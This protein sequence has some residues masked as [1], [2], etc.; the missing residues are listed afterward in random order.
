MYFLNLL[1]STG[2]Q[3]WWITS[4]K[5]TSTENHPQQLPLGFFSLS[6]TES[7]PFLELLPA[8]GTDVSGCHSEWGF[9][10]AWESW[11]WKAPRP[12][13]EGCKSSPLG[14]S[15]VPNGIVESKWEG[16]AGRRGV[17][18][19][20]RRMK[21]ST[22]KSVWWTLF[23]PN[24][25]STAAVLVPAGNARGSKPPLWRPQWGRGQGGMQK[26]KSK[27]LCG[28]RRYGREWGHKG[29]TRLQGDGKNIKVLCPE[30]TKN[31]RVFVFIWVEITHLSQQT[32]SL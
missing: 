13:S 24:A 11:R 30:K 3:I 23:S 10:G 4:E 25:R 7:G 27:V 9:S 31:K 2:K 29:V 14:V 15:P 5:L 1:W 8:V 12:S 22:E 21:W 19:R 6:F 28:W 17:K 20:V 26:G 16:W 18:W 32:H